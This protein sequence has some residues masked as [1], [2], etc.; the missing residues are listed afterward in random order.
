MI[1]VLLEKWR[2][3]WRSQLKTD[4]SGPERN[5]GRFIKTLHKIYHTL[6]GN[7]NVIRCKGEA[8]KASFAELKLCKPVFRWMET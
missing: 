2:D 1:C 8:L 4:A 5:I 6:L 7:E 3:Q